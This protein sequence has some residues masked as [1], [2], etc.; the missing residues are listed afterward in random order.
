MDW[1]LVLAS[2]CNE[3]LV[4]NVDVM[5]RFLDHLTVGVLDAVLQQD[6]TAPVITAPHDLRVDGA[7]LTS[8]LRTQRREWVLYVVSDRIFWALNSHQVFVFPGP[9]FQT[10][11]IYRFRTFVLVTLNE[12]PSE[13]KMFSNIINAVA[14]HGHCNVMPWHPAV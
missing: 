6:T 8:R 2:G 3:E 11:P 9:T 13:Y 5:L 4:F 7:L 12:V 1:C 14:N 10:E